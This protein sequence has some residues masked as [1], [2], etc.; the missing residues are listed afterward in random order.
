MERH[1]GWFLLAMGACLIVFARPYGRALG[2]GLEGRTPEQRPTGARRHTL[3]ARILGASLIA[4]GG[5][6]LLG[7]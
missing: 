7:L 6:L 2:Y 5:W 3:I 4:Y 1:D